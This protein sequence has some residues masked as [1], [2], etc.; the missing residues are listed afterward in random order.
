[1]SRKSKRTA[2]TK[3]PEDGGETRPSTKAPA[4]A[5]EPSPRELPA[6]AAVAA[7]AS[8]SPRSLAWTILAVVGLLVLHY[9][10]AARSLLQEN[11]TVDEVAHLPAGVTYWQKGTFRLYPHNPPLF[12]LV[13]ALP[14]V[15]ARP[16]TE[17]LF[18][19]KSWTSKSPS[20]A[21]FSQYFAYFNADRYFELFQLARLM[22]PLFTVVGGL[23]VFA[24]SAR[25]Y[26]RLAG[27]LSLALWVFCPNIL[28]HARLIT[29]DASSTAMGVAAT[30]VFWRY[31]SRPTWR[32]AVVAGVLLGIAQLSKF[33][34]LLLYAVWP[35]L[36]LARLM[37]VG[38]RSRET[39]S[40]PES[41]LRHVARGFLHGI[42]IVAL[43][44]LMIDA[45]YFFEGVG[46]PLGKFEFGSRDPHAAGAARHVA[47]AQ[48]ES[49]L[50]HRLAIPR[51][52]ISGHVARS[53]ADAVAGALSPGIR[54]AED[55]DGRDPVPLHPGHPDREGRRGAAVAA[56]R[57][58]RD[59]GLYGLPR[60]RAPTDRVEQLLPPR[61]GLQGPRGHLAPRRPLAGRPRGD[62]TVA[63]RLVRR[64]GALDGAGGRSSSP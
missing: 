31:L 12:K 62:E 17:P 35:F 3:R 8:P 13:A 49:A 20:P 14:V 61:A 30:Y 60:R 27:L 45:G 34:M 6:T 50:R 25:L 18:P 56:D 57:W 55:R 10:L 42:A 53:P 54:R 59:C 51:Q 39:G 5:P 28:A 43:S 15:M 24:W 11:P 26:G 2:T 23:V 19:Y 47:A 9:V 16:V 22:M 21:T 29:S 48:R 32:W 58:R 4:P 63:G 36:W 52:S 40:A 33:S 38:P 37:I 1:M 7:P 46:I 44:I 41:T 64:A